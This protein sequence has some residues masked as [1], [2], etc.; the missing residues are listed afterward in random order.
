MATNKPARKRTNLRS[1]ITK[2]RGKKQTGDR[3]SKI[4]GRVLERLKERKR[5]LPINVR[6]TNAPVGIWTDQGTY[7]FARVRDIEALAASCLSQDEV[8]GKRAR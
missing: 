3:V 5:N 2:K 4:A 8:K 7:D 1:A 6:R